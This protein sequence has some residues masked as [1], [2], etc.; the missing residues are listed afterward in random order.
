MHRIFFVLLTLMLFAAQVSGQNKTSVFPQIADG[1]FPG[2]SFYKTTFMV[3]PFENSTATCTLQLQGLG[4]NL[5]QG[6]SSL[7]TINVAQGSYFVGTTAADQSMATGYA[8]LTCSDYVFAQA[9]YSSYAADGTK[10]A[11]A[12]VFASDGDIG[13]FSYRMIADQRGSNLGIAIAN[14]TDLSRTYRFTLGALSQT[15]TVPPRSSSPRFLTEILPASANTVGVL[16]IQS[17]DFSDFYAIGIRYTGG[18]FTTV[19]AN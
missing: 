4:V 9:L 5:G 16:K 3:L 17:L 18:A 11:E 6:R 14:D 7:F 1:V 8:V 15:V 10:I 12:T 19:P 2:G 13:A